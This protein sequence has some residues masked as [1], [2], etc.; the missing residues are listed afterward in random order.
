MLIE[1]KEFKFEWELS[2]GKFDNSNTPS[3]ERKSLY[4]PHLPQE[5][6]KFFYKDHN[7]KM[8]LKLYTCQ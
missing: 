8:P 2:K 1:L 4:F 3:Q 7:R 6:D 5:I